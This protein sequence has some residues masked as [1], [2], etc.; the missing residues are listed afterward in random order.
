MQAGSYALQDF[1][2]PEKQ[3]MIFINVKETMSLINKQI[4]D[5][6]KY[7]FSLSVISQISVLYPQYFY[8]C[9]P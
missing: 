8:L 1:L 7:F 5:K 2:F 3:S 9:C 6:E 4:L